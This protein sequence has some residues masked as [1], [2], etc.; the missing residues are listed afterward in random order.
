M[1]ENHKEDGNGE[2]MADIPLED[3]SLTKN[4]NDAKRRSTE[5]S[6]SSKDAEIAVTSGK[7]T[8]QPIS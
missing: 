1:E 2:V 6:V 7:Q 4:E 3:L 5:S 8:Y